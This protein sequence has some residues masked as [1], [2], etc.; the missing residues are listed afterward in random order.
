ML[1]QRILAYGHIALSATSRE[2]QEAA[3][4]KL[5]AA[6]QRMENDRAELLRR[7]R[8]SRAALAGLFARE[9]AETRLALVSR[10]IDDY[11]SFSRAVAGTPFTAAPLE[12]AKLE[13]RLD[14]MA[15]IRNNFV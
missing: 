6:G 11:V 14:T 1:T 2:T 10:E 13:D 3:A 7:V 8:S 9:D 15:E 5:T 12:R 4:A